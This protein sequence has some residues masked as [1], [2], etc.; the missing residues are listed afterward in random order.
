MA[1][2]DLLRYA[3]VWALYI[4]MEKIV[5]IS[6]DY[7]EASGP[8]LLKFHVEPPWGRGMKDCLNGCGPLIKIA[9]MHI[10]GKNL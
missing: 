6:N 10:Y 4:C 1:R 9:A 2:S 3:F 8:M 7:S 5:I